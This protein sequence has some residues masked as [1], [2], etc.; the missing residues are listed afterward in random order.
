MTNTTNQINANENTIEPI[1]EAFKEAFKSEGSF[2]SDDYG[3]TDVFPEAEYLGNI[4]EV[5]GYEPENYYLM[6]VYRLNGEFIT[7]IDAGN[8][9]TSYARTDEKT[10]KE[11]EE[12]LKKKQSKTKGITQME[13]TNE[14]I[15][16]TETTK[17]KYPTIEELKEDYKKTGSF[18]HLEYTIYDLFPDAEFLG[19]PRQVLGYEPENP[20]I[21]GIYRVN[22]VIFHSADSGNTW[23]TYGIT[24]EDF[25]LEIE[26]ALKKKESEKK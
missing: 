8:T 17:S 2:T 6:G 15:K 19:T 11:I 18:T 9:W 24:E 21:L 3:L 22:G 14:Q 16:T 10:T 7:S 4:V 25:A 12:A 5:L 23:I 26:E 20:Y 1:I 13:N